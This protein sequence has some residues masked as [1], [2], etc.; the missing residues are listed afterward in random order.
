V[1]CRQAYRRLVVLLLAALVAA[2]ILILDV[3]TADSVTV[4]ARNNASSADAAVL[5]PRMTA[6]HDDTIVVRAI[7][8]SIARW[9]RLDRRRSNGI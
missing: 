6:S 5:P 9:R 8:G 7:S 1:R 3:S 4:S 2:P